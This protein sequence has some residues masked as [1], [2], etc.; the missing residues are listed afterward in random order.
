MELL[1]QREPSTLDCTPGSLSI[2]GVFECY[3]LEDLVREVPGQPRCIPMP[4]LGK[5]ITGGA[6][7]RQL[8]WKP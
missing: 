1:V 7:F 5:H 4:I 2:D 3:T 6:A 8:Y